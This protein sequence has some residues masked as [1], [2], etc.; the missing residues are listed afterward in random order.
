MIVILAEKPS[1]GRDLARILGAT[2]RKD[3]YI[4]GNGYAVTWA[5]GHLIELEEPDTYDPALKKWNLE[6]LP[7][8]PEKFRLK[9]SSA[10]GVKEQFNTIKKLFQAA[11]SIVCATDA[12]REGE[13]IFRYILEMCNCQNKPAKRLWIS[14]LTDEAIKEGFANLKPLEKYDN[15]AAAAKCR[16]QAD[17]IVGLNATRAYTVCHSRGQGVLSVGRVQTPVLSLIVNRDLEIRNFKPENYWELWTLYRDV[18]FKHTKAR[19]KT[20]EEA[21][22]LL[23][24]VV[25]APFVITSV[26]EKSTSQAPPQLFDLTGLQKSMNRLYSFTAND[27]LKIAQDLYEKKFISYPRTDSCYLSDDL[28]VPCKKTLHALSQRYPEPIA[29]LNLEKLSKSK[30]YFNSAKVTDHHAI[31]PTGQMPG[32]LSDRERQVYEAIVFRFIAIFYPNCEKAHTTI[33]GEA[34]KEKFKAR[35][36]RIVKPGWLPLIKSEAASKSDEDQI[37]PDF[38]KGE[39]GPHKPET[40]KCTTKPPKTFNEATLLSSMETA[41]KDVEDDALKEAMKERGLG[42]PATRAGIIETLLKREYIYKDK[43]QLRASPKGEELIRLM[44]SQATLTSA[45]MTAD[46]EYR[47]KEIEKGKLEADAFIS[48]IKTF[49]QEIVSALK[50][51]SGNRDYG[52][53]PL[54]S[55][56][57]IRGKTGYG[58]S[59]W[60]N[61]CPFRFHAVQYGVTLKAQEVQALL[62]GGTLPYPKKI[63]DSEGKEKQGYITLNMTDGAIG[64]KESEALTAQDGI[65]SC[66]ECGSSVIERIKSYSCIGC[67]FIIWKKIAGREVSKTVAKM[68]LEGKKSKPL[69]GFRSRAGKEFSASLVLKEGRVSFDFANS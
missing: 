53:C 15:L 42:T 60:K 21:Q 45:E 19:F 47:L 10:K 33:T 7:I 38:E 55:K 57:V 68:L 39:Q 2:K 48:S 11:D 63:I 31:I 50:N 12:G 3:G 49:T 28:Y 69:K 51:G 29:P 26:T 52:S 6:T 27:T 46:W 43:K 20:E 40:K 44:R 32:Q 8:L 35:G 64:F 56:P 18:K 23:D 4:E 14:S 30:R 22:K 67:D 41:G 54:C 36:T 62:F 1:V 58:C 25:P 61:G 66:P 59:D 5:Y 65:G 9:V 34:E 37:L 17:W 16:A 13:L 24:K